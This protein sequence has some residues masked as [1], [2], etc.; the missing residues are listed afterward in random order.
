[1]IH[2]IERLVS[3]GKFRNYQASGPVNFHKLTVIYGDN[4]GGKTTLTSI[5]R[6]LTNN[7]PAIITSRISTNHTAPQ[8]GQVIQ[9]GTPQIFHT[10]GASGWTSPLPEIEIF[11][12]HFVNDNVYS[13]FDF[14]DDHKKRLHQFVIGSQGVAIQQ[15]IEQNKADKVISRAAIDHCEQQLVTQVGSGLTASGLS[16]FIAITPASATN[17]GAQITAAQSALQSANANTII[18]SLPTLSR[19]TPITTGLNFAT[20]IADLQAT[21]TGIQDVAL[22]ALFADHCTDLSANEVPNPESW[23]KTGFGYVQ[24]KQTVGDGTEPLICPFCKQD[25]DLS[26]LDILKAYTIHF[27]DEFN[28]LVSRIATHLV[29]TQAA[30]LDTILLTINNVNQVNTAAIASWSTH[31]PATA[32]APIF[33]IV[34]DEAALRR[35]YQAVLDLV[36]EKSS[37]PSVAA[38]IAAVTAFQGTIEGINHN[39]T[40]YNLAVVAYNLAISSFKAGIQSVVQAQTELHRLER[41]QKRFLPPITT[42]C[43]S[44]AAE[45]RVLDALNTAYPL[46]VAQQAA[47]ATAFLA[48]YKARINHYLTNVFKT[49]FLIDNVVHVAPQGQARQSKVNYK[50]TIDGKDISFIE[51]QPFSA[52]ECLSE[53]DKSTIALALFLSKLDIDPNPQDK[54]LVFDDPLSSLDTNRRMYTISIIKNL[55]QTMKQVIVLSHNEHFLHEIARDVTAADKKTL[56]ITEN[57]VARASV[58]EVCNLEE[59]AQNDYFK[60]IDELEKFRTQ[61]DLTKKD[62]VLGW[63]RNV[64]ETHLRFKF[65]KEVRVM[66]GSKTFGNLIRHLDANGVVF[67]DN[68]NRVDIINNLNLINSISWRPHHGTPQPNYS[69]LGINPHSITAPEL[70]NLIQDTLNLVNDQL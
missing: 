50:L 24:K 1:M 18:Q 61:P 22:Q 23:L 52:R 3:I 29:T 17:I 43:S 39:I 21:S 54:I 56:R 30:N 60:H 65:Y 64:L 7:N 25:I 31:L 16:A 34:A 66:T 33:N 6:S 58:L 28:A 5:L 47:T 59:L 51:N 44:R 57:F 70:D 26:T 49:P 46:L 40:A 8:A 42:L 9:A 41:I 36:L 67:R 62:S 55:I 53:G 35:E 68:A 69:T 19:V 37:N 32:I 12:T 38:N 15:Q 4:G 13:G 45:K 63:L 11:D 48:N 20:L 14:T 10:F 27:D 2:K